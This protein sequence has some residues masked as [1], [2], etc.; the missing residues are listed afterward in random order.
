MGSARVAA[1]GYPA[2]VRKGD[3]INGL[4]KAADLPGKVF[5]A[6]TA[7]KDGKVVTSGG[8]VLCATA[9]GQTVS[10]AQAS[11]YALVQVVNWEGEYHRSDIGYRAVAREQG[12]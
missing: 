11:A 1:G 7:L 5:H 2:D 9:L 6:G 8:R 4:D 10:E 12:K 3:A